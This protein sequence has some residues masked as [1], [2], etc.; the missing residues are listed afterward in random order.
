MNP[1]LVT[2]LQCKQGA[3]LMLTVRP[4]ASVAAHKLLLMAL[5]L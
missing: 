3:S 2:A 1:E 4:L 5:P